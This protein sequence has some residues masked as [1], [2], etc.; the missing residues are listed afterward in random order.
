MATYTNVDTVT[1]DGTSIPNVVSVSV[2]ET[3]RRL[4]DQSEGARGPV[5]VGELD[6]KFTATIEARDTGALPT[7]RGLANAGSLL[8]SVQL[9]SAKATKKTYTI[10]N[11]VCLGISISTSQDNPGGYSYKCES[12]GNDSAL[13]VSA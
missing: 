9:D 4:D 7:V 6:T 8:F 12:I 5:M 1:L 13:S 2:E 3:I 10:T 11:M